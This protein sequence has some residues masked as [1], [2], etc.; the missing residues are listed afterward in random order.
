MPRIPK[1]RKTGE[2]KTID[3]QLCYKWIDDAKGNITWRNKLG[4]AKEM[5]NY[6]KPITEETASEMGH[7][8]Q[9]AR[10]ERFAKGAQN[11]I[12]G[13]TN[14][15]TANDDVMYALGEEAAKVA[16]KEELDR[17][18]VEGIKLVAA[19]I[20]NPI[21]S[22]ARGGGGNRVAIQINISDK[23]ADGLREEETILD[24][25]YEELDDEVPF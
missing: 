6:L 18:K 7:L 21:D 13:T 14:A 23:A 24:A 15:F 11:I 3:G 19:G 17:P 5:P 8:R 4:H 16:L 10:K 25:I 12:M 22:R 9:K 2:T 1:T 20:G